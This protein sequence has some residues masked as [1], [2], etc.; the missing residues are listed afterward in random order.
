[1]PGGAARVVVADQVESLDWRKRR[2]RRKGRVSAAEWEEVRAK[3]RVLANGL[4]GPRLA[5]PMAGAAGTLSEQIRK[6]PR[7]FHQKAADAGRR[8][9]GGLQIT[10][11]VRGG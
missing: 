1:M 9:R 3:V 10:N 11:T 2:A 8:E 7:L 6:K 4:R 5:I